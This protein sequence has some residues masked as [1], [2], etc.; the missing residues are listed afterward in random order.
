MM[1]KCL[2][3]AVDTTVRVQQSYNFKLFAFTCS[4]VPV[5]SG[6]VFFSIVTLKAMKIQNL[7]CTHL[8]NK[9]YPSATLREYCCVFFK[10]HHHSS[11]E[12]QAPKVGF[13]M[14]SHH[15]PQYFYAIFGGK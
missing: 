2:S 6:H 15:P 4:V 10:P 8:F 3:Y 7:I 14:F 13:K 5:C 11:A 9:V 12:L 1:T